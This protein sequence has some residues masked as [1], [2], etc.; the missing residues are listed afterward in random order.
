VPLKQELLGLDLVK[1]RLLQ[2]IT[3]LLTVQQHAVMHLVMVQN[4]MFVVAQQ[5]V[6][7]Q[8]VV[9]VKLIAVLMINTVMVQHAY[10]V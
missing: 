9:L 2:P 8:I 4:L 5:H 1:I 10:V 7:I 3:L 6:Q